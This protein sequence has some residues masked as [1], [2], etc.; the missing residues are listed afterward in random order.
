MSAEQR[1]AEPPE[2]FEIVP[3]HRHLRPDELSIYPSYVYLTQGLRKHLGH[4]RRVLVLAKRLP[5]ATVYCI[6]PAPEDHPQGRRLS[7]GKISVRVYDSADWPSAKSHF[8][9]KVSRDDTPAIYFAITRPRKDA[10]R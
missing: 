6:C 3:T 2:G 1:P 10:R 4:A 9:T 5:A 8:R 7:D